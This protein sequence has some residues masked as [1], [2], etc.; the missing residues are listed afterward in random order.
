MSKLIYSCVFFKEAYLELVDL[1][2][3]S[4]CRHDNNIS[5]NKYLIITNRLLE[6][7]IR[8]LFVKFNID[9]DVMCLNLYTQF[10]ACCAR[11][12]IFSYPE[13]NKFQTILYLDC[14][15]LITNPLAPLLDTKLDDKLYCPPAAISINDWGISK[16]LFIENDYVVDF[17]SH[18]FSTCTMLFKNSETMRLLFTAIL[19]HIAVRV[20][21][22]YDLKGVF[23][24]DFVIYQC[25]VRKCYDDKLLAELVAW[26]CVT[27]AGSKILNHFA[28]SFQSECGTPN[29]KALRMKQYL[30][31]IGIPEYV[32]NIVQIGANIGDCYDDKTSIGMTNLFNQI[33]RNDNCIFVEPVPYLFKQLVKNYDI[34]YPN[35][36]FIFINKAVSNHIGT[37]EMI[38][39]AEENDFLDP[40]VSLCTYCGSLN[41]DH[42]S[43]IIIQ[44]KQ[45][46]SKV[47]IEV[48]DVPTTTL[49]EI[50]MNSAMTSID[51][52]QVD[53]EGH[54]VTILNDYDFKI[55]P[56]RIIFEHL[57][58][59]ISAYTMLM[60]RLFI[61]GYQVTETNYFDVTLEYKK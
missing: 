29:G 17:D 24:E 6:P 37:A 30:S 23:D 41:L 59:E 15:I 53:A 32:R 48:I 50:I 28:A 31:A 54:D 46:I 33:S 49:N 20:P 7:Q 61:L 2:L 55:L 12:H 34:K 5:S 11:L 45:D 21:G 44:E 10:G 27:D 42:I 8:E 3:E 16:Q 22:D 60:N 14:D 35:N 1:L 52:L 26:N 9:G 40:V 58:A 36:K 56:K 43:K 57:H 13:I 18:I 38:I 4:Y 47:N 25:F 19:D 39:A 51:L